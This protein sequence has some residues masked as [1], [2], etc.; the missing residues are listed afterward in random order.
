LAQDFTNY[1]ALNTLK[2]VVNQTPAT[3][4]TAWWV[5]LHIGD[6]GPDAAANP[7]VNTLRMEATWDTV[8]NILTDGR[9]Q[10]ETL[11]NL[12]W[13]PVPTDETYTHISIW[14]DATVG[15]PWYKGPLDAPVPV[16]TG[17][18]FAFAAGQTI[19]HA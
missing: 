8:V 1:G 10:A 4:P 7:A 9:A 11:A 14:D 5:K 3:P 19:D 17:G 15:N 13:N 12:V 2:W 16:T 18:A 6:P